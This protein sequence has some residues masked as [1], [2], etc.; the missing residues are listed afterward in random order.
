MTK[1]VRIL[2]SLI[3]VNLG[4]SVAFAAASPSWPL[5]VRPLLAAI[6][7]AACAFSL[8]GVATGSARAYHWIRIFSIAGM[9]SG[10]GVLVSGLYP[11]WIWPLEIAQAI[12]SVAVFAVIHSRAVRAEFSDA[13]C[14]RS[15]RRTPESA[16]R[17]G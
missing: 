16:L 7:A 1:P 12:T 9:V 4:V 15:A 8:R 10:T 5:S 14:G 3:I 17:A 6:V 13:P 11:A 2:R